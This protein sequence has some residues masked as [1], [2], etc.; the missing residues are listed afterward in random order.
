[1][2]HFTLII[3]CEHAVNTIPAEFTRLFQKAEPLLNTHAGV[4]Y[5]ALDIATYLSEHLPTAYYGKACV[6]RLLIDCN[7]S[8]HHKQCF[9]TMTKSLGSGEKKRIID[10]YYHPFRQGVINAVKQQLNLN[11]RVLHLS[12]HSF[13][14]V[15]SGK[16]RLA[17]VGLLYDP[18]RKL[19]RV[20]VKRWQHLLTHT[21]PHLRVRLNYPY[22]G[23]SDGFTSALRQL[24]ATEEYLGIEVETNQILSSLAAPRLE[25][26]R[27]F[28][29]TLQDFI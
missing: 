3:S 10:T 7:R 27:T 28:T 25:I 15:L 17:D 2:K 9:S 19:E 14:P 11:R 13:T 4:D 1:M 5:G 22:R 20:F 6:S 12:I 8:L 21:A 24:Y 18:K 29:Q 23:T 16:K 26:C